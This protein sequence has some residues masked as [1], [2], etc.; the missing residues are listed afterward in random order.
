VS[1]IQQAT[2]LRIRD[3]VF[4]DRHPARTRS[5]LAGLVAATV[6]HA[7]LWLWALSRGPSLEK[8]SAQL[9]S[10]IHEEL[11]RQDVIEVA[12]PTPPPPT[13]PPPKPTPVQRTTEPKARL[14][15]ARPPP[16]AKA[17]TII[18]QAP[19]PDAPVD[20]TGETF[21]TG[22][23]TSYVGGVSSSSGTNEV[24][25]HSSLVDPHAPPTRTPGEPDLSRPVGLDQQQWQC[26]WPPEADSAE[27]DRQT[28]IIRVAVAADGTTSRV[29]VLS[30]P[31]FG[32]GSAARTCARHTRFEAARDS[33]GKRIAALSPPIRVRFTR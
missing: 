15:R 20:L 22:T 19:R 28:V 10:R 30:D 21:V 27:I 32:F 1:E 24:A 7:L 2:R 16:P 17:G 8:W 33:T 6:L 31:G 18:A 3:V 29:D 5:L 14:A 26:P 4:A 23:S 11:L 13:P 25:V 9:A 12:Q